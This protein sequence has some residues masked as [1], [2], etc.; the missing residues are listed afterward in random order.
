MTPCCLPLNG[1][2]CDVACRWV[3]FNKKY[4]PLK[5]AVLGSVRKKLN[6]D[7]QSTFRNS[8]FSGAGITQT[9]ERTL[10]ASPTLFLMPSIIMSSKKRAVI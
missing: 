7:I 2:R 3:L 10:R 5:L 4:F 9:E 8:S 1:I 6:F